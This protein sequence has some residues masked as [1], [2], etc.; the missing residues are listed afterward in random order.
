[1]KRQIVLPVKAFSI[2]KMSTRDARFK[3]KAYEEW[4]Y[5]VFHHLSKQPNLSAMEDLRKQFSE[6]KHGFI[7][8]M[9]TR[10]PKEILLTKKGTISARA[11]DITNVEKPLIDLLFDS[12][13][14]NRDA[15]YGCKNLKCDDKHL[16]EIN[17]KK[18]T[19]S[20]H[21]ITINIELV[22]FEKYLH[23]HVVND[24]D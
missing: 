8:N 20:S 19:G 11:F 1:M 24:K 10:F 7:I 6:K 17:S 13:Y 5:Q 18:V 16:L 14:F 21:E 15:P 23:R 2:N 12:K 22:E 4:T 9:V 3:T